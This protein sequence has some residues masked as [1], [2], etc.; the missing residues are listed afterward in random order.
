MLSIAACI[1]ASRKLAQYDEVENR[2]CRWRDLARLEMLDRFCENHVL[3]SHLQNFLCI[4]RLAQK[5]TPSSGSQARCLAENANRNRNN[6]WS[7][8]S[9]GFGPFVKA[10]CQTS[11]RCRM[12]GIL[13]R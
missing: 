12:F 13:L 7:A 4:G 1:V 9:E 10:I 6:S 8:C 11:E 5:S 3:S 2:I